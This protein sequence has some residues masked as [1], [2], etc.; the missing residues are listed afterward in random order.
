VPRIRENFET[1]VPGLYIIGELGGMGL[2]RNA[3]EQGRQCIDGVARAPRA[4]RPHRPGNVGCGPAGLA[5]ALH[6]HDR[7]LNFV[8]L[9]KEDIGG[10]VR[11]YPRKKS[12]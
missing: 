5:A 7:G 12:S 4:Q 9:E 3:F 10:T 8:V 11:H 1:N 2:I 6:A